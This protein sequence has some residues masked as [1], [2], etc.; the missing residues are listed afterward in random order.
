MENDIELCDNCNVMPSAELHTCP[1]R[2]EINYDYSI[3]NCCEA[4]EHECCMDI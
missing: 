1:Y 2:T 4:C 3:C